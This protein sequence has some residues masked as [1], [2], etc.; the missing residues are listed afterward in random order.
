MR[1]L[2]YIALFCGL[3]G[4]FSCSNSDSEQKNTH[5]LSDEIIL[6]SIS[7]DEFKSLLDKAI[8]DNDTA[9]IQKLLGL[10]QSTYQKIS[11]RND[12]EAEN[13]AQQV[14]AIIANEPYLDNLITNKN[15]FFFKFNNAD[16]EED[17]PETDNDSKDEQPVVEENVDENID[18]INLLENTEDQNAAHNEADKKSSDKK[19]TDTKKSEDKKA[20]SATTQSQPKDRVKNSFDKPSEKNN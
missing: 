13:F 14:K 10:A 20:S 1:T 19:S 16:F 3:L 7:V 2:L 9:D 18:D 5:K 8:S 17:K 4:T 6:D 15:N 11:L 12:A